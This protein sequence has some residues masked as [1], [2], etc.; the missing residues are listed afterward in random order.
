MLKFLKVYSK[1]NTQYIN[2]NTFSNKFTDKKILVMGSGPSVNDVNWEKLEY[3]YIVTTSFFY[4]NDKIRKLPNIT[5]I[6]LTDLVDLEHPNLIEFIETNPTCTIAFEPKEHPFYETKKY[7]NFNLKYQNK[8]VYYNTQ[9]GKKEGVAGRVCYFIISPS[10][11]YYVGIDGHSLNVQDEP[12]NAFRTHLKGSPD[13][14]P[15]SDFLNSHTYFADILY[16]TSLQTGTKLYNL[17]EGYNYN[18][19]TSYSKEYFPLS[20]KIKIIINN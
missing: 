18:C 11:L 1:E 13:G 20:E 9:Y 3:D 10:H 7:K 17:G 8:I 5:H 4:L 6:T 14:Y 12:N 19:S 15:Q 16:Q 2:E